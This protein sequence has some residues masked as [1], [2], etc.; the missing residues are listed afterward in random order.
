MF[1]CFRIEEER[2]KNNETGL[3]KEGGIEIEN[4]QVLFHIRDACS[5]R[6]KY[7][8]QC[9]RRSHNGHRRRW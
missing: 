1:G 2:E 9:S 8:R 6:L 3:K 5:L 7:L 4:L